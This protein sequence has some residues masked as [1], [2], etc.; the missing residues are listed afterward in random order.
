MADVLPYLGV[1]QRFT[2]DEATNLNVSVPFLVGS[3]KVEAE[4]RLKRCNLLPVVYGN[5]EYVISQNPDVGIVVSKGGSVVIYTEKNIR[6]K[7][8]KVPNLVGSSLSSVNREVSNLKLNLV[9]KGVDSSTV[10]SNFVASSQSISPG[11]TVKQ[12][13]V[14]EVTF[15]KKKME[16]ETD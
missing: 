14:I 11:A 15:V 3:S 16:V 7:V 2:Q 8:V 4:N 13:S 1:E 6:E 12:S 10:G 5:G 9:I